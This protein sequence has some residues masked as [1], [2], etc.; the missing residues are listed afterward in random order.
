M[1]ECFLSNKATLNKKDGSSFTSREIDIIS[2]LVNGGTAKS[3]SKMLGISPHT[4]STHIGNVRIGLNCNSQEQIIKI[5][6]SSDNYIQIRERYIDLMLFRRFEEA[7]EEIRALDASQK[8]RCVIRAKVEEID[9]YTLLNY[10]RLANIK[11]DIS[12]DSTDYA[13]DK[14]Y[15]ICCP[16]NVHLENLNADTVV[17]SKNH[18]NNVI[19]LAGKCIESDRSGAQY[20]SYFSLLGCISKIYSSKDVDNILDEFK[21]YYFKIKDKNHITTEQN[22][23]EISDKRKTKYALLVI[24]F[25]IILLII[26]IAMHWHNEIHKTHITNINM[27]VGEDIFL[28]RK[29]LTSKI[30]NILKKQKGVKFLVLVGQ[31]GIGKTTL[32]R[33]YVNKN[34]AKIK[35]EINASTEENTIKSFLELAIELSQTEQ[36]KKDDLKYIQAIEDHEI[37]KKKIVSFVFSQLKERKDWILLFDNIDDF[38]MVYG[39]ILPNKDLCNEGTIIIT[40]RNANCSNLSFIPDRSILNIEYLEKNEKKKLFCDILYGERYGEHFESKDEIEKIDNFLENIPPM[41]LDI[42]NAAYYIKNTNGSFEKYLEIL[43][44]PNEKTDKLHSKFLNEGMEYNKT[45]YKLTIAIFD[46]LIE[47]NSNFKELLLFICLLDSKNIPRK[48]LDQC[49][50]FAIVSDFLQNLKRFFSINLNDGKFSFHKSIQEI[51]L[52][53]LSNLLTNDEKEA[54]L[55]KIIDIMTPYS[56]ILWQKYKTYQCKL[57][58]RDLEELETHIKSMPHNLKEFHLPISEENRYIT[59]LLLAIGFIYGEDNYLQAKHYLSEA[60]KHNGNNGYIG[61]YE[62][63]VALLTLGYDYVSLDESEDA[64]F[65]LNK[66]LKFCQNLNGME[67]LKACGLCDLGRCYAKTNDFNRA[68]VLLEEALSIVDNNRENWANDTISKICLGLSHT[69]ADHYINKL[70]GNKS[71]VYAQK[72]FKGIQLKDKIDDIKKSDASS[73]V[74]SYWCLIKAYNRMGEHDEAQKCA[75]HYYHLYEKYFKNDDHILSKALVDIEYGYT[76]LRKGDLNSALDILNRVINKKQEL[77]DNYY[78]FHAIV[79][80]TENLIRLNKLDEAYLDF[81]Y[82]I[83]QKGNSTDNYT[84]LLFCISLYHAFII[85]YRQKDYNLALKHFSDFCNSVQE[86]CKDFLS[87]SEY[88]KLLDANVFEVVIDESQIKTYLQNSI[89]IFSFIYGK[90]HPF[91]KYCVTEN[92]I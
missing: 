20:K 80:R 8:Y 74:L 37:K 17:V 85:K 70:E 1:E 33:Y 54:V 50:D 35:W 79:S 49:K 83:K 30:D 26:P 18:N 75:D 63:A 66:G 59:K 86:F 65:W 13:E 9:K 52:M 24:P 23:I 67:I 72:S 31:G 14:F 28:K 73:G 29:D 82:S 32:A 5:V 12:R 87:A 76:L 64:K 48:Y 7:L 47:K 38:K 36:K 56:S 19:D 90:E 10:L 44:S 84:R 71:V 3:S 55:K 53:H 39:F 77:N 40:T 92:A 46:K 69:Y 22:Y 89:E 68:I 15:I 81:K 34:N 41:P 25:L 57:E 6:E 60:L 27:L 58:R 2:C 21:E 91:V 4:I 78:L 62:Y 61:N 11:V 45:R 51:G 43:K 16:T 88:N 42:S